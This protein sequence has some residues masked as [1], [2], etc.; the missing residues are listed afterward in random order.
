MGIKKISF[1]LLGSIMLFAQTETQN[2]N[3]LVNYDFIQKTEYGGIDWTKGIIVVTGIGAPNPDLPVAAQRPGAIRAAKLDAF[4]N[5]LEI[6]KGVYIDAQTTVENAMTA[7]DVI[8]TRIQ[9]II[10]NFTVTDIRY[11]SDGSIEVDV[12]VPITGDM[13]ATLLPPEMGGMNPIIQPQQGGIYTGLIIDARGLKVQPAM[14][15]KILTPDEVEVYGTG[16]VSHDYAIKMGIV[17]YAKNFNQARQ[18]E[19]VK[20]NPLIIKGIGVTGTN[21]TDIIISPNDAMKI[22]QYSENL[23]FL[24]QCRVLVIVD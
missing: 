22:H 13:T 2:S 11:M 1:I 21:K 5:V 16:F 7:S 9:G 8:S 3:I 23:N 6:I 10:R 15:P 17:G 24:Q 14:A 19:R 18:D 4:R 20:P 12:E